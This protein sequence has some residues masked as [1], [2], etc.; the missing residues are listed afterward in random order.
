MTL[1]SSNV[2]MEFQTAFAGVNADALQDRSRLWNIEHGAFM[3]G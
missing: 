3:L 2:M 1:K